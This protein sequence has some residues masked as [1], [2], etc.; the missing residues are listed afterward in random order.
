MEWSQSTKDQIKKLTTAESCEDAKGTGSRP[1]V[2]RKK[3]TIRIDHTDW[4][5]EKI[6]GYA[7]VDF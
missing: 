3:L 6:R 2:A 1:T 7:F 4:P 5:R